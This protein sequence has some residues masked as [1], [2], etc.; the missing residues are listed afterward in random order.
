[1]FSYLDGELEN[2]KWMMGEDFTMAD[3]AAAAPLFYAQNVHPFDDRPHLLAY[4]RRLFERPSY[5]KVLAEA[6]PMLEK[7]TAHS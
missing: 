4:A 2:S 6:L 5:Q 7:M 3:C 1:M